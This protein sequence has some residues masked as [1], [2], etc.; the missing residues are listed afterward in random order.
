MSSIVKEPSITVQPLNVWIFPECTTSTPWQSE[1]DSK[2]RFR[3]QEQNMSVYLDLWLKITEKT[4]ILPN[5]YSFNFK[6][7]LLNNKMKILDIS[8]YHTN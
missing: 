1:R 4:L 8:C 3:E 5:L 7:S 6:T 2:K